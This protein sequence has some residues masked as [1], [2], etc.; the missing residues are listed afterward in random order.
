MDALDAL[1]VSEPS[2]FR[3]SNFAPS[4]F[5]HYPWPV[6]PGDY[7]V[8]QPDSS[9]AVAV[10]GSLKNFDIG[11]LLS[12]K[13]IAIIGSLSTENLGIEHVVKNVIANPFIRHLVLFGQEISGHLPGDA[14]L[15]LHKNGISEKQKII[16]ASGARPFLKNML[17]FEIEHFRKQI[18]PHNLIGPLNYTLLSKIITSLTFSTPEPYKSGLRVDLVKITEARPVKKLKLDPEGYFVIMVMPGNKNPILV[19]HYTNDGRLR[20]IIEGKDAATVCSTI[21]DMDLVSQMDHAAYLGRELAKAEI[22]IIT[23][24]RYVQ[25]RAQGNLICE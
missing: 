25:D 13:N 23:K 12:F 24:E 21:L 2:P 1:K 9:V 18:Q 7:E 19:E 22:S 20:H 5:D 6:Q 10:L 4:E 17:S 3:I 8:L 14:I 15:N 16:G 11:S